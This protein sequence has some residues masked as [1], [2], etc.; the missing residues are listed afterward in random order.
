MVSDKFFAE[1][2]TVYIMMIIILLNITG[3]RKSN[4][5]AVILCYVLTSSLSPFDSSSMN[6]VKINL[7]LLLIEKLVPSKIQK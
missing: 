6:R 7:I 3:D 1:E 5:V 4:K 2:N